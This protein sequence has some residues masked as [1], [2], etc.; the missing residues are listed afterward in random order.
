MDSKALVL[1]LVLEKLKEGDIKLAIE[2]CQLLGVSPEQFGELV[3]ESMP[4]NIIKIVK[5]EI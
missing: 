3:R 4:R 2:I 5:R 1:E